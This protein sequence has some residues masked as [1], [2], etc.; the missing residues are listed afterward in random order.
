MTITEDDLA[1]E[2]RQLHEEL[3]PARQPGDFTPMEYAQANGITRDKAIGILR[4]AVTMG[5]VIKLQSR[6]VNG[7]MTSFYKKVTE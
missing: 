2:L 6:M 4:R 5:K 7:H 1:N 3:C